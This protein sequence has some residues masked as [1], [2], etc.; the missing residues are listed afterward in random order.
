MIMD[1]FVDG[2]TRTNPGPGGYGVYVP[3][4]DRVFSEPDS[5]QAVSVVIPEFR[6]FEGFPYVTNNQMELRGLAQGMVFFDKFKRTNN[7]ARYVNGC[8]IY[9]DSAYVVNGFNSW[10]DSWIANNWKTAA[11][12]SVKNELYWRHINVLKKQYAEAGYFIQVEWVKGHSG[13]FGNEQADLL[14]KRG[15][16]NGELQCSPIECSQ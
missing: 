16:E 2:S 9:S 12:K 13:I 7:L 11:N 5:Y 8:R 10:L 6:L 3:M 4:I 15:A 1:I 14:A